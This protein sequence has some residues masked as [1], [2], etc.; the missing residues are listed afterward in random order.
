MA[1]TYRMIQADFSSGEIDP[2]VE[3]NVNLAYRQ[4]GLKESYN[5]L[6]LPNATVSKR[7]GLVREILT[8]FGVISSHEAW[9]PVEVQMETGETCIL[10]LGSSA[11]AIINGSFFDVPI[12]ASESED[13]TETISLSAKLRHTAV[14]QQ[15]VFISYP[16]D[17]VTGFLMLKVEYDSVK[18]LRVYKPASE[19]EKNLVYPEDI[20]ACTRPLFVSNGRLL[21]AAKNVFNASRQR[22][23]KQKESESG[24]P[25]WT[26][27]F[28][29]TDYTYSYTYKYSKQSAEEDKSVSITETVKYTSYDESSASSDPFSKPENISQR[30]RVIKYSYVNPYSIGFHYREWTVTD[31]YADGKVLITDVV[32]RSSLAIQKSSTTGKEGIMLTG[33]EGSMKN[34]FNDCL[35]KISG[36]TTMFKDDGSVDDEIL[37]AV[38]D[39][40]L[41]TAGA[42]DYPDLEA[43]PTNKTVES[44]STVNPLSTHAIQVRENDMYGASIKWI[45][46]AGRIIV[47]TNTAIHIAVDQYM[48]PVSFDLVLTSYTGASALQPKILNQYVVFSSSDGKKLYIGVYSDAIKGF[49]ITEATANVKHLFLSGIKDY[50]IS[51]NPYRVIYVLTKDNQCRVCIP[52]FM[53]DG[54]INFAW[55]TWD[56]G[57]HAHV[58]Y[59]CFD[60]RQDEDQKVYFI[61]KDESDGRGWIYSLDYREPYLYG[62]DDTELLLDFADVMTIS[63]ARGSVLLSSPFLKNYDSLDVMLTY[64][65]GKQVV[66]RDCPVSSSDN[67]Y[68]VYINYEREGTGFS[69]SVTMKIGR[70][71]ETR[72]AL[73]QQVLPNNAGISLIAKHSIEKLYLQIYRSQGGSVYSGERKI[74]DL[75]QFQY[76]KDLYNDNATNPLTDRPYTFSGVYT[77][78]RPIQTVNEDNIVIKTSDPYPFNLMS[79]SMKYSLLEV[80]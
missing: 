71:Y 77:I 4:T 66:L 17:D 61:M 45:T 44:S 30:V 59:I 70:S 72:I 19:I 58:E 27:D 31:T 10:F 76:G 53:A 54:T 18:G 57:E 8:S 47:G 49:Q 41:I 28:T 15:Y 29:L 40:T 32:V 37:E 13:E 9:T 36:V 3:S 62:I 80:Y 55:S 51:D 60:R 75:L 25:T 33:M 43:Q 74:A 5:T 50:Y 6:H 52:T 11:R 78:D 34:T 26:V 20:G 79:I 46:S 14:Y 2:M 42:D 12:Y 24:F 56:F 7:P 69:D 1:A 22:T 35:M 73:L 68:S 38:A 48:D 21:L 23:E 67:G 16:E 63:N 39:K 65:D 64:S